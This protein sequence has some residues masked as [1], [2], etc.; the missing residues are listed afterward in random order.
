[1][2]ALSENA[3]PSR[4]SANRA[5]FRALRRSGAVG[6]VGLAVWI[7]VI[8]SAPG[9]LGEGAHPSRLRHPQQTTL[10]PIAVLH[11]SQPRASALLF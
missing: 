5:Q 11:P 4:L 10:F 1:M 8:C 2:A 3:A 7:A 6:A 9:R